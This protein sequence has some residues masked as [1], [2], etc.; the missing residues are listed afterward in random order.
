M[1]IST[2]VSLSESNNYRV[3]ALSSM[4]GKLSDL[5]IIEL[6]SNVRPTNYCCLYMT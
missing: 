6:Q 3:I 1:T 2:I 4:I 5:C